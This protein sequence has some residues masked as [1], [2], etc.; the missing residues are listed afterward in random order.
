LSKEPKL[1]PVKL[2][3]KLEYACRVLAQLARFQGQS[4]LAHIDALADAEKIPAN[5][6]VQILN[7]LR[8]SG[9][10]T[11]KRGKQGGYALA[12]VPEKIGLSEIVEAV[13]PELLECNF[14]AVG[15][16]G[17]RVS[18][19]WSEIGGSFEEKVKGYTL[20]HFVVSDPGEMYYI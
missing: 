20:D 3:H 13:E 16:S 17:E 4:K 15:H 6:L 2:S 1:K 7:E 9:L 12:R 10:I 11:S 18:E 5:Y 14:D 19:I 8:T